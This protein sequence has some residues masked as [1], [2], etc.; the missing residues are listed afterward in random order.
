LLYKSYGHRLQLFIDRWFNVLA[1]A[2]VV[3]LLLGFWG[4]G[5]LG[6]H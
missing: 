4:V 2:F 5:Q 3:L 1:V 6:N